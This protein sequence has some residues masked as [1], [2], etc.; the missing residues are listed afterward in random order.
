MVYHQVGQI[1]KKKDKWGYVLTI[2]LAI[3]I[4]CLGCI[5]MYMFA[6]LLSKFSANSFQHL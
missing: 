6:M 3:F 4:Y 5:S 2:Q 1:I